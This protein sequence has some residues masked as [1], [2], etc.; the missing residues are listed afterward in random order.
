MAGA[1]SKIAEVRTFAG[2]RG[3]AIKEEADAR[4]G[5]GAWRYYYRSEPRT[6]TPLERTLPGAPKTILDVDSFADQAGIGVQDTRDEWTWY[7]RD[8]KG[9]SSGEV[10][11]LARG[12]ND[13]WRDLAARVARPAQARRLREGS[14]LEE[15]LFVR[16]EVPEKGRA[17]WRL[18]L[19][20]GPG[21]PGG[22]RFVDA[23]TLLPG[24]KEELVPGDVV[25][26]PDT[27][28]AT[29]NQ[30]E[31]RAWARIADGKWRSLD[32]VL[33]ERGRTLAVS[34]AALPASVTAAED[35]GPG[36]MRLQIEDARGRR[37]RYLTRRPD[38]EWLDFSTHLLGA[39][40]RIRSVSVSDGRRIEVKPTDGPTQTL[41]EAP[42]GRWL[43]L[44]ELIPRAPAKTRA[45]DR[46]LG[47]RGVAVQTDGDAADGGHFLAW[48]FYWRDDGGQWRDLL[49]LLPGLPPRAQAAY[50]L[51]DDYL[52]AVEE[53]GDANGN[54]RP[55]EWFH[56]LRDG[57]GWIQLERALPGVP[58]AVWQ[59]AV[60]AG[61]QGISAEEEDD[62]DGDG[63]PWQWRHWLRD[64]DGRWQPIAAR[65]PGAPTARVGA[66]EDFGRA[67]PARHRRER[68]LH[69]VRARRARLIALPPPPLPARRASLRGDA[70]LR[71][72]AA[73]DWATAPRPRATIARGASSST[74]RRATSGDA[75][76]GGAEGSRHRRRR[77]GGAGRIAVLPAGKAASWMW[78]A[79]GVR[80]WSV[81]GTSARAAWTGRSSTALADG[82][83]R[84]PGATHSLDGA[85]ASSVPSPILWLHGKRERTTFGRVLFAP[86]LL[87]AG[88]DL[89]G[90]GPDGVVLLYRAG[91]VE[92]AAAFRRGSVEREELSTTAAP[93]AARAVFLHARFADGTGRLH[94]W[95]D[96]AR[97]VGTYERT[98]VGRVYH[99]GAG[100]FYNDTER[101]AERMSF[102]SGDQISPSIPSWRR[103]C[104]APT[105]SSRSWACPSVASSSSRPTIGCGSPARAPPSP[106]TT[107]TWPDALAALAQIL[108]LPERV[109]SPRLDLELIAR[110]AGIAPERVSVYVEGVG[111]GRG[112]TT[113]PT[114]SD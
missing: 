67:R 19:P 7:V 90:L 95:A 100:F 38:G 85:P 14:S 81:V 27:I 44:G 36:L 11:S 83:A 65:L 105:S 57:A 107:S 33:V 37:D 10:G 86:S 1:P 15:G 111:R 5:S 3:I 43:S 47:L 23:R 24:I 17:R 42:D 31:R 25:F 50:S 94:R 87:P 32:D 13:G 70:T 79:P 104:S 99:D 113:L 63:R 53:E 39:P 91:A 93:A 75:A 103:S 18:Y 21:G 22:G 69:L 74:T 54:G 89:V 61:G 45:I 84:F 92:H 8:P 20:A 29:G 71:L 4:K 109:E 77:G 59:L 78:L 98:S 41:L 60:F 2:T 108:S 51:A 56:Y 40:D 6:W 102:R 112:A 34:A 82:T 110:G 30:G 62:A 9:G 114:P 73:R 97:H 66:I 26:G 35:L 106:T 16:D 80:G 101:V 28:T 64:A 76:A 72:L 46:F 55:D 49:P 58:K 68:R 48:R 52:L 96:P 12:T 88:V